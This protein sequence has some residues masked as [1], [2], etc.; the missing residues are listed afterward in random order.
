MGG[1]SDGCP[2]QPLNAMS[3]NAAQARLRVD[4]DFDAIF[5]VIAPPAQRVLHQV[6][7]TFLKSLSRQIWGR[8]LQLK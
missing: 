6:Q 5:I 2:W 8:V 1:S 4:I 3:E 7:S